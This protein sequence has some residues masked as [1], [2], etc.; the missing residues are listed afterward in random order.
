M[1][2]NTAREIVKNQFGEAATQSLTKL[3]GSSVMQAFVKELARHNCSDTE[4]IAYVCLLLGMADFPAEDA[5]YFL[6]NAL[7]FNHP[8]VRQ[9][10]L[11]ALAKQPNPLLSG[12]FQPS[13]A[14]IAVLADANGPFLKAELI[15]KLQARQIH[16]TETL[17]DGVGYA[18]V[19][20]SLTTE[21]AIRLRE[22]NITPLVIDHVKAWLHQHEAPYLEKADPEVA[23][24]LI[25]LL[26]SGDESNVELA[27]ELMRQGG[28]PAEIYDQVLVLSCVSYYQY[29]A[30]LHQ[31]VER[32][33][34]PVHA[35]FFKKN[36]LPGNVES[37]M[38]RLQNAQLV[39][40]LKALLGAALEVFGSGEG[41]LLGCSIARQEIW[42]RII[43]TAL[44]TDE[45]WVQTV[46][47][48]YAKKR[49]IDLTVLPQKEIVVKT[50][51]RMPLID[52][53]IC[54][55]GQLKKYA[56]SFVANPYLRQITVNLEGATQWQEKTKRVADDIERKTT[57]V[58]KKA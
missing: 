45:T 46:L 20:E 49:P 19:S 2:A 3:P 38:T 33:G 21:Q 56:A 15:E 13:T 50:I 58:V 35:H 54:S 44:K 48:H 1:A 6:R 43:T 25:R 10:T 28:I 41:T 32:F 39:F 16:V 22:A 8:T 12:S 37:A 27:L 7:A 55:E 40:D 47:T 31:L 14:Q 42:L 9:H 5:P 30:H 4:Q 17:S 52:A 57:I 53:I 26:L 34:Q 51:Q 23:A 36:R 29:A 11:L 18:I 24:N